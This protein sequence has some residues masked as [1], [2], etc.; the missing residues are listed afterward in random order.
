MKR[1]AILC[2]YAHQDFFRIQG[3]D[4]MTRPMTMLEARLFEQAVLELYN[5]EY[6]T[7]ETPK[8]VE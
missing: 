4:P 7:E 1:V 3:R 8:T 5:A 2:R 6:A